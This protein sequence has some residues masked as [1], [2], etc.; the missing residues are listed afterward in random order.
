M[1]VT[2]KIP[3]GEMIFHLNRFMQD[4]G[5]GQ[6]RKALK[7]MSEENKKDVVSWLET[8]IPETR[9]KRLKARYVKLRIEI[10]TEQLNG[11]IKAT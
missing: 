1:T 5:I 6:I 7:L 3:D 2:V 9:G 10:L 11:C 4:A 8:Q